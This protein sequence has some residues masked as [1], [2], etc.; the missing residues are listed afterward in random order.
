MWTFTPTEPTKLD[1][2][3]GIPAYAGAAASRHAVMRTAAE[4]LHALVR[5]FDNKLSQLLGGVAAHKRPGRHGT[6]DHGARGHHGVIADRHSRKDDRGAPDPDVVADMHGLH[7]HSPPRLDLMEVRIVDSAQVADEDVVADSHVLR[8]VE[9]D[10][11]VDE[12]AV[13]DLEQSATVG[14][15]VAAVL[16]PVRA[17]VVADRHAPAVR[18]QRQLPAQVRQRAVLDSLRS[19]VGDCAS[20]AQSLR[21]DLPRTAAG[22]AVPDGAHAPGPVTTRTGSAPRLIVASVAGPMRR[23]TT[24]ATEGR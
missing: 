15:E 1:A 4:V 13:A 6:G 20:D 5:V 11:P 16:E 9:R 2:R 7:L 8:G 22:R 18:D 17:E 10:A 19:Q 24:R 3:R 12:H 23:C 14:V 21:H